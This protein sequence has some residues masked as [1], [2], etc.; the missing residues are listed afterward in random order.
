MK[1][2][3]FILNLFLIIFCKN[4]FFSVY[5]ESGKSSALSFMT[6]QLNSKNKYTLKVNEKSNDMTLDYNNKNLLKIDSHESITFNND[7]IINSST[8]EIAL[9]SENYIENNDEKQ[10]NL[11][12][13][14]DFNIEDKL[15]KGWT[16]TTTS[17]CGINKVLGGYCVL[18]HDEISKKYK[19]EKSF[20]EIKINVNFDFFD[21]WE[22]ESA[23]MKINDKVVWVDKYNWCDKLLTYRCKEK[24]INVCG[25]EYPD[26]INVPIEIILPLNENEFTISFGSN[27]E[28]NSCEASWGIENIEIY[29]R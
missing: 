1:V 12:L 20:S 27:I 25:A 9:N 21:K 2:Y 24:G 19:I 4:T 10:F 26:R 29:I 18:S 7:L 22:G 13:Y 15:I 11:Y 14:E 16:K 23:Y 28:K 5:S 3:F 8:I 6:N 17:K